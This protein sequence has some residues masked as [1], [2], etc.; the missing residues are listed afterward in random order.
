M[1][2]A[3]REPIDNPL[4]GSYRKIARAKEHFDAL[5]GQI[6]AFRSREPYGWWTEFEDYADEEREYTVYADV[7]ESPD[8]DWGLIAGD[9]INNLRASLDH[10]AWRLAD[11]A[12]RNNNTGFP[13]YLT[14]AKFKKHAAQRIPGVSAP[15]WTLIEGAQPYHWAPT[16]SNHPLAILKHLSNLDKHR[17]LLPV[18]LAR[19]H[20]HIVSRGEN[21]TKFT[22]LTSD[23]IDDGAEVMRFVTIGEPADEVKVNA[24]L[25]F[26]VTIEGR[27]LRDFESIFEFIGLSI[28][29][30]FDPS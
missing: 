16:A 6:E 10:L 9:M 26:E 13:I 8:A 3:V 1:V 2:L 23:P 11:P 27:T 12:L 15:A 30:H 7:R 21:V 17:A 28:L 5:S 29:D 19:K 14:R 20:E 4:H 22:Y 18:A 25:S 24:Y